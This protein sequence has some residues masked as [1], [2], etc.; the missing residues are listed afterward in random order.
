[1]E[2]GVFESYRTLGLI[3]DSKAFKWHREGEDS[4]LTFPLGKS[5]LTYSLESFQIRYIGCQLEQTVNSVDSYKDLILLASGSTI[6]AFHKVKL[7]KIF[8]GSGSSISEI[9]VFGNLLLG[10][11]FAAELQVWDCESTELIK[12]VPLGQKGLHIIHPPTHLNKVIVSLKKGKIVLVNVKTGTKIY[13]FP[14]ICK[15][16]SGE[17]TALENAVALDTIVIGLESGKILLANMLTDQVL[18]YFDQ[19]EKVTSVSVSSFGDCAILASSSASGMVYL[20]D[21]NSK[22]I[23]AQVRAHGNF[24]VTKV[25]FVPNELRLITSSGLDNSIKQWVFDFESPV[26]RVNKSRE[27]FNSSPFNISFYNE[28][29]ILALSKNSLRDLS[30]LNEHQSTYFSSKNMKPAVKKLLISQTLPDF[31][32]FA[33]SVNREKDWCNVLTQNSTDAYLWSY[34]NKSIGDKAIERMTKGKVSA[35]AVSECGNFGVIGTIEGQIEKFNMQS[36]LNQFVFNRSHSSPIIGIE[37]DSMNSTLI[38]ASQSGELF[39]FDFFTGKIKKHSNLSSKILKIKLQKFSNLLAVITESNCLIFDIRTLK[40]ARSFPGSSIYEST[41]SHDS[42]WVALCDASGLQIWDLPNIKLIDWISFKHK[43]LSLDFSPDGRYLATAHEGSLGVF[44]WLNKSFYTQI[45]INK[46]PAAARQIKGFDVSKGKNFYSKKRIKIADLTAEPVQSKAESIVALQFPKEIEHEALAISN[47]PYSRISALF[48]LD[49]I[50]DRN[51]PLEPAKK[52]E[53]VPFFLPDSLGIFKFEEKKE[54]KQEK[55]IEKDEELSKVLDHNYESILEMLKGFSPAKIEL[56][57]YGLTGEE[58]IEKFAKFLAK[59]I[60]G[61]KDFDFLQS[62]M[63]CF[64]RIHS[65]EISKDLARMLKEV[66]EKS[67]SKVEEEILFDISGLERL[68]D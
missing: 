62:L 23:M 8:T 33:F 41:F 1:M 31:S 39:I 42:R 21:L 64:L 59:M 49:E 37:L 16:I 65:Q 36:G 56:N 4:L 61:L 68:L 58:D 66:Q 57:L 9:M 46:A 18:F 60:E 27:G 43:V 48:R 7:V 53:K 25:M 67:W 14:N 11:N 24:E 34:E 54:E 29:H 38:S 3:C 22:K 40:L 2:S 12:S 45:I 20:W 44:L 6:S 52:P 17:V 55:K 35:V 47:L 5:F 30:M 51:K 32:S 10:L 63:A 26:P 50:K 19:G 28:N 15:E 13:D